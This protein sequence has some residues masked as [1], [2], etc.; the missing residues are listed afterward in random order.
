[1]SSSTPPRGSRERAAE[2]RATLTRI[3][4]ELFARQGYVATSTK[5]ITK[6]AGVSEGLVFHHFPT[7]LDLL[8][9]VAREH[10]TLSTR[11]RTLLSEQ[12]E[13]PA[14]AIVPM[15]ARAFAQMLTPE[16]VETQLFRVLVSESMT[17][18]ELGEL[19]RRIARETEQSI[20]DYLG[21]RMACGELRADLHGPTGA[22]ALLGPLFWFFITHQHLSAQQWQ[23]EAPQF[24]ERV[25]DQWLRGC[26]AEGQS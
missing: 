26:L 14:Q 9:S 10:E 8:L 25:A 22:S 6:A 19:L 1:M 23:A 4:L 12:G 3:A 24:A 2:T 17:T 18:P 15:I 16:R 7:K 20:A 5:Q 11:I 13:R 21:Q